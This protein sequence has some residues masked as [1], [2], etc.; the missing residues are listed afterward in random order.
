MRTY[1]AVAL[2][3]TLWTPSWPAVSEVASAQAEPS[4]EVWILKVR[5]YA[6]S[7]LSSTRE[8]AELVPRSTCSHCGSAK[9][10]DHRVPVLPSTAA[11]AGKTPGFSEEEAV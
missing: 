3:F 9:A 10:E 6:A 7:Q 8:I 5:A 4:A 1:R 2:T 11:E